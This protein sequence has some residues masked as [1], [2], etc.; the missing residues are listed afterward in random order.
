MLWL[1]EIVVYTIY[2]Y[3][4]ILFSIIFRPSIITLLP[5][6]IYC[7]YTTW[8]LYIG[9]TGKIINNINTKL[10]IITS[11]SSFCLTSF[12][13]IHNTWNKYKNNM[14][15]RLILLGGP[16]YYFSAVKIAEKLFH[17]KDY[18]T[19]LFPER[20]FISTVKTL[21]LKFTTYFF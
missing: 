19:I 18:H 15:Y 9:C 10:L 3:G 6:F 8:N 21:F 5:F 1:F 14:L 12:Y 11:Y 4:F 2:M 16:I 20:L 13:L 17:C 7:V